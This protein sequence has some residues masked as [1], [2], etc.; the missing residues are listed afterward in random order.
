VSQKR[1]IP[2]GVCFLEED[3]CALID[4]ARDGCVSVVNL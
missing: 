1:G 2:E 3:I 4:L